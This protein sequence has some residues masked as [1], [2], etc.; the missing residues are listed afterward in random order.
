MSEEQTQEVEQT[1]EVQETEEV[2]EATE[3]TVE[4][5][6][7]TEELFSESVL[8][9]TWDETKDIA[10]ARTL[11]QETESQLSRMMIQ[12]EK[13]KATLL[14]RFSKLESFMFQS[15]TALKDAKKINPELTYELKLP[16]NEGEKGYF[17]RKDS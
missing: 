2:S 4:E 10:Q 13:Q 15:A 1:E 11:L 3:E 14:D 6:N 5:V 7:D 16:Q 12:F 8:E 17:I 9:L